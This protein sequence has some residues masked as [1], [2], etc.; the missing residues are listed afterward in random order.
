MMQKRKIIIYKHQTSFY[1]PKN[2]EKKL[3]E[4]LDESKSYKDFKLIWNDGYFYI[5]IPISFKY[6]A[7]LLELFEGEKK[8]EPKQKDVIR[9]FTGC[10]ITG[11]KFRW[12]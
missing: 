9:G 7:Y 10:L 3:K 2:D 6:K 11:H 5:K 1:F 8:K 12:K 4:T